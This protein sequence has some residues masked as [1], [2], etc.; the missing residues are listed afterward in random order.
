MRLIEWLTR[1]KLCDRCANLCS[2]V[3]REYRCNR[4]HTIYTHFTRAPSYCINFKPREE[5]QHD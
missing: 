4:G 2:K 1:P 5:K 3:G